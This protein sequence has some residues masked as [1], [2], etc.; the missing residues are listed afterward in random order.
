[1]C[2]TVSPAILQSFKSILRRIDFLVQNNQPKEHRPW[3]GNVHRIVYAEEHLNLKTVKFGRRRPSNR[4]PILTFFAKI[5]LRGRV[6]VWNFRFSIEI[7]AKIVRFRQ[8]NSAFGFSEF[9]LEFHILNC[10]CWQTAQVRGSRGFMSP[11]IKTVFAVVHPDRIIKE[12][13][14]VCHLNSYS[15]SIRTP[16]SN[17][18]CQ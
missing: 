11:F 16:T 14:A 5:K 18:H 15:S 8:N 17:L 3:S 2:Q 4:N 1:M 10:N 9:D 12:P 7:Y 13:E 6:K